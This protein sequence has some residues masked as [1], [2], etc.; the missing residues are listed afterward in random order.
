MKN[1]A[2]DLTIPLSNKLITDFLFQGNC[3]LEKH[4]T[5]DHEPSGQIDYHDPKIVTDQK[6]QQI[7]KQLDQAVDL[8]FIDFT[9]EDIMLLTYLF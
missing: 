4:M 2:N 5:N 7:K 3:L 8:S 1:I 6:F 9:D